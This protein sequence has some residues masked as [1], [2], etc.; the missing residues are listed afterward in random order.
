[1]YS[2]NDLAVMTG[3]TTRTIRNYIRLGLLDGE[4][5][6]GVW[7]FTGEQF[8]AFIENPSVRPSLEAKNKAIVYDFLVDDR[9]NSNAACVILDFKVDSDE[10]EE[11]SDHF[12]EAAGQ[13]RG[14]RLSYRYENGNARV[15]L[16]GPEDS[17]QEIL[18]QYYSGE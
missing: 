15:I 16:S 5:V 14:I 2:M 1:M 8:S 7:Q 12:C 18:Q 13:V 4:K 3:L 10:A 9:K 11:I 17:V 6:D